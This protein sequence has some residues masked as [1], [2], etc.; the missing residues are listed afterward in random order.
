MLLNGNKN[1]NLRTVEIEDAEFIF[2]IRQANNRNKFLSPVAGTIKDQEEWIQLY[3]Q[4]ENEKKEFYFVIE[5]KNGEKLGLGRMYDFKNNSFCPGSFI[6]KEDAP[7]ST[8]LESIFVL[9]DFAFSSLGFEKAHLD[10]RKEN[11]NVVAFHQRFGAKIVDEN[12]L[13]YFFN[14]EKSDYEI[15]KKKYKRYA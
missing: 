15:A 10:V 14:L 12:E 4:R 1:T 2:H 3:K 11:R 5:S 7:R 6:I 13:N 8:A 9:Y